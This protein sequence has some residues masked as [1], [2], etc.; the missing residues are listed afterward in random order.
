M[1]HLSLLQLCLG[2]GGGGASMCVDLLCNNNTIAGLTEF[3]ALLIDI[4]VFNR[5]SKAMRV[6]CWGGADLSVRQ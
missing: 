2:V 6:F 3:P 1:L 5:S 4:Y